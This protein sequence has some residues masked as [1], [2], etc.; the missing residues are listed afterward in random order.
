VADH[1]AAVLTDPKAT[2]AALLKNVLDR[3][4]HIRHVKALVA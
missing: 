2:V 4:I 1:L 3:Q